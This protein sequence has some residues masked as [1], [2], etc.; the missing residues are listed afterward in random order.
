MIHPL[1]T[2]SAGQRRI[3]IAAASEEAASQAL[4]AWVTQQPTCRVEG[5]TTLLPP[6]PA[7]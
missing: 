7:V 6:I 5:L 4:L 3:G 2:Y 1:I